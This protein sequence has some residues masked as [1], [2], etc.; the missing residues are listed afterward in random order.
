VACALCVVWP[1]TAQRRGAVLRRHAVLSFGSGA[2]YSPRSNFLFPGGIGM[3]AVLLS[4][5]W[6][7]AAMHAKFDKCAFPP[8][9]GTSRRRWI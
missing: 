6:A 5:R 1:D 9:A 2:F 4:T 8:S 3:R 7:Q